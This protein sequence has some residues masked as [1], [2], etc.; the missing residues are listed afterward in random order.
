LNSTGYGNLAPES[1]AT[2]ALP[3]A[4]E[5][6]NTA[7]TIPD[8]SLPPIESL[9]NTSASFPDAV[10]P[11]T[12]NVM[13]G[14]NTHASF[15]NALGLTPEGF[16]GSSTISTTASEQSNLPNPPDDLLS[17]CTGIIDEVSLS[18]LSLFYND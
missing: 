6:S 12:E 18:P 11:P 1:N 3:F 5:D 17:R 16:P 13:L 2:D 4:L 15:P 8:T 7:A 9:A 14:T 10:L